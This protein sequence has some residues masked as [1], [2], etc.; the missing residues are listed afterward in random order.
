[1]IDRCLSEDPALRYRDANELC[2]ALTALEEGRED[3]VT[4]PVAAGDRGSHTAPTAAIPAPPGARDRTAV[5][6]VRRRRPP[7][8]LFAVLALAA[9]IAAGALLV[10]SLTGDDGGGGGVASTPSTSL[11]TTPAP[12]LADPAEQAPALSDW[13]RRHSE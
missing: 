7:T 6:G 13:I 9:G 12:R 3:A 2:D 10:S 1:V 11:R 4:V 8:R 5:R